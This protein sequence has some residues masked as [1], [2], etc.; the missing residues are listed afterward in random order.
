MASFRLLAQIADADI[1][2]VGE[3]AL[4][5][6][7]FQ[8]LGLPVIAGGVLTA[9]VWQQ[10]LSEAGLLSPEG[11]G[12]L[13]QPLLDSPQALRQL[14]QTCQK[15]LMESLSSL[16]VAPLLA[17]LQAPWLMLRPS[18]FLVP[19]AQTASLE[20]T[21]LLG[22]VQSRLCSAQ[23]EAV[24]V[25]L[26]QLWA[27]ALQGHNLVVWQKYCHTLRQ[28]RLATLIHPLYPAEVSGTLWL[29]ERTFALEA[30]LG[31]GLALSQGEAVPVRRWTAPA[32]WANGDWQL[33]YQER[34]YRLRDPVPNG[35]PGGI[36]EGLTTYQREDPE[37]ACPLSE[38]QI[39][40]LLHLG[41][42]V[43]QQWGGA[44]RLEW[45]L[46]NHPQTQQATL[47][48]T[49]ANRWR[50]DL[51]AP[52][53]G[54]KTVAQSVQ[55]AALLPLIKG[56]VQGI[57]AAPG[58]AL[59]PA[60]VLKAGALAAEKVLPPGCI[61]VL[62]DLQP[63]LCVRLQGVAGIVTE[64]GGATCHA[65][66]L[67][68]EL[69]IPA[70]VG[71]PQ[72]TELL[73]TGDALWLDGDRGIVYVLPEDQAAQPLFHGRIESQLQEHSPHSPEAF[74]QGCEGDEGTAVTQTQIMVNLSQLQ[75]L[76][77]LPL[78]HLDGV[79][80]IRS[81]WLLIDFLEGR[82][83][84]QWVTDGY[85]NE[86]RACLVEKLA[87]IVAAFAPKPVRYRSM[88]LRSHEWVA[89]AGSPPA[90]P[91]PMLGIRGAF[92]YQLDS[93]LFKIELAA[94]AELQRQGYTNL[95]LMLPF[96]RTVE[97]FVVCRQ[98][99]EQARLFQAP[100]FQLWIMAEV[101]SV[102]FLLPA[103]R[104]AG[105]QGIAIGTNDLT[106]LLLAVDRDQPVMASA[107]DE[108]HPAVIAALAHLVQVSRQQGLTCS[109]CGQAPVRHPELIEALVQ[110]GISSISVEPGA[111]AST[112]HT[113]LAAERRLGLL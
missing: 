69:N 109:I 49:Q 3:K 47:V 67:A 34:V 97:E 74:P 5:L 20:S 25:A 60:M 64:R 10:C 102:L 65:A 90:E 92:S 1:A 113:I 111:L 6:G 83:P 72:A 105:V 22:L 51:E 35:L 55:E 9:E 58:R 48:L 39:E 27:E 52:R 2:S 95:Q 40:E 110:W 75:R 93:R 91:N 28:V 63:E 108:R 77:D 42:R 18:L 16:E 106:Q 26:Q 76:S 44:V 79:G 11:P 43:Q 17:D 19:S 101:P 89:L 32:R 46:Y 30:V 23:P 45:L 86:L 21:D 15:A 38:K 104:Q 24:M 36:L 87:P 100:G 99:V 94:L 88:D 85:G 4:S 8:Q 80:L 29:G 59:A 82:H 98:W 53:T 71:A 68:R 61:V 62:P 7:R 41:Q 56:V 33:G 37:L 57:G 31:L 54:A 107:Y 84:Q 50:E 14:A 70:V 12:C 73:S 103:Y 78:E 112:R 96:V 66:I 81:E 13:S